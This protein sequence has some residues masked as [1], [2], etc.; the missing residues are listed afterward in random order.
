M[1]SVFRRRE[2]FQYLWTDSPVSTLIIILNLLMFLVTLIT[3][4]FSSLNLIQL[5]GLFPPLV[6]ENGEYYRLLTTMFL[7]G[8]TF[9]LIGNL[10]IGIFVLSTALERL[11]GSLKFAT[12]YF[13]S[14]LI[15][16][17]VILYANPTALSIGASGAIY[18][19]LGALLYVTIYRKDKVNISD[20]SSI[21]GLIVINI[22]F[23][24]LYPNVSIA[25][26]IG[27]MIG[28][29]LLSYLLIKRNVVEIIN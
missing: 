6:T 9:H 23:T 15:A 12:I 18:G 27:G 2:G 24:F 13:G 4:G 1:M 11:I 28:G 19:V 10:L 14:G 21:R 7:H 5:G 8:S 29:F 25:G 20:I 22:I 16:S 3:G 26:H 17:L